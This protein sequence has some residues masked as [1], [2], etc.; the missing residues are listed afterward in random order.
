MPVVAGGSPVAAPPITAAVTQ[1]VV[2]AV[3]VAT[4]S[5]LLR[6]PLLPP[7]DLRLPLPALLPALPPALPPALLPLLSLPA[8]L[9]L[10]ALLPLLSAVLPRWSGPL[11]PRLPQGLHLGDSPL[12]TWR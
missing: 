1:T 4:P 3:L 5:R 12:L 11:R 8:L 6:Q 10:L 9:A 7:S 2:A